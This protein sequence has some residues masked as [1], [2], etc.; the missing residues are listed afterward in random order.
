MGVLESLARMFGVSRRPQPNEAAEPA[1]HD[2]PAGAPIPP[3]PVA[4]DLYTD[5]DLDGVD[6][7]ESDTGRSPLAAPKNRQELINELRKNYTEVLG[8]VRK[9]DAHLD[10]QSTR[11]ERL[12]ELAERSTR[13]AE[14]L[15]EIAEQ[16]RR[17][18]DALVDLVELTRD[19]RTRQ[20]ASSERLNKTALQQLES[21]QRQ[22]AAMQAMQASL[23]RV[24]EAEAETTRTMQ[25]LGETLTTLSGS[26]RDL[27]DTISAMRE[28]DAE[29]EVELAR[30]V[31][32]SQKWLVAAVV[33]CG[34]LAVGVLALVLN[35]VV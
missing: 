35:R 27:G 10:E 11:G 22:T 21:A 3:R 34:L 15:P 9:V 12:L 2:Q 16:N 5:D 25:G 32:N 33:F 4:V 13:H 20:D 1:A 8:L 30:L 28:T 29:R 19:L 31:S 7:A 23:H 24:G 17:I 14:I 26:T 18:A 6:P